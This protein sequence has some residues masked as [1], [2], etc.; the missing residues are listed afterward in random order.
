MRT[1][2]VK[3]ATTAMGTAALGSAAVE[4]APE[5]GLA[6]GR[7]CARDPAMIEAAES[8][9]MDAEGCAAST[10]PCAARKS[11]GVIEIGM[12]VT[13]ESPIEMTVIAVI[14]E[15]RAVGEVGVVVVFHPAAMPVGAPVVP[16]PAIA[17]EKPD[18]YA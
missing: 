5:A 14:D 6:A 4:T 18:A 11:A 3:T 16:S 15:S 7:I 13:R 17:A 9:G 12:V 1:A 10:G 2:T 8:V